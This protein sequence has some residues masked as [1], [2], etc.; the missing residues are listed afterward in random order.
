MLQLLLEQLATVT[1]IV[2]F[3]E[4]PPKDMCPIWLL[5]KYFIE[6]T[7]YLFLDMLFLRLRL[8]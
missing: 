6:V 2:V 3:V 7:L 1:Y 4:P 5:F 8:N